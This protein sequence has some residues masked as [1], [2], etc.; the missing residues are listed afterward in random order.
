MKF[1]ENLLVPETL[2]EAY[3]IIDF[4]NEEKFI[5]DFGL[6][7]MHPSSFSEIIIAKFFIESKLKP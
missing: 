3:K 1:I 7:R 5:D 2:E 4:R 6:T